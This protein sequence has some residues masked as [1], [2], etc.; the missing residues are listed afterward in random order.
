MCETRCRLINEVI[1]LLMIIMLI[2]AVFKPRV[3]I[4]KTVRHFSACIL[5]EICT[6]RALSCDT[7]SSVGEQFLNIVEE[8]LSAALLRKAKTIAIHE[9]GYSTSK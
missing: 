3:I 4:F 8:N 2:F 6:S 5:P 7:T 1:L 9:R